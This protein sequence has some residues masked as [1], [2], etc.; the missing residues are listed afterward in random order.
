MVDKFRV[1]GSKVRL[2]EVDVGDETGMVSLRA[3]DEQIDTLREVSARSGAVVLRNCTLELYQGKHIRLSV[4][5]WGK[6]SPY[7]DQVASTP[8]PPSKMNAD[9]NFSLIDLSEVASDHNSSMHEAG[10]SNSGHGRSQSFN[11]NRGGRRPL[12]QKP[13]G[14]MMQPMQFHGGMHYQ[15]GGLHGYGSFG[16][17]GP[18]QQAYGY[19]MT[20]QPGMT[21]HQYDNR[22]PMP[23]T[24]QP[25]VMPQ[26]SSPMM[27]PAI[28][29]GSPDGSMTPP[30]SFSLSGQGHGSAS[31]QMPPLSFS[32]S[33]SPA[34]LAR[35]MNPNA[36]SFDPNHAPHAP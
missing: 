29:S 22:A 21:Y 13:M 28:P 36:A 6:L 31:Q 23:Y 18:N 27:S 3:R 7:P 8:P 15:Q 9:R 32:R 33:E 4:T 2:A 14:A 16:L 30:P 26:V 1:D 10:R 35:L 20:G 25:H 24:A 17:E 19:R 34:T 5:K 11:R 12:Q